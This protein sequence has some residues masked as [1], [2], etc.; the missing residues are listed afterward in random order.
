MNSSLRT[1]AAA[2]LAAG[3]IAASAAHAADHAVAVMYHRFGEDAYPSTNTS[4][5]QIDAHIAHLKSGGFTV[6]PLGEIVRA[7]QSGEPLPDKTVAITIDDAY[8]SVAKVGLPKLKAA[9]FPATIFVATQPIDANLAGYMSWDDVRQALDDG[10]DIGA[11]TVSHA[12]LADLPLDEARREIEHANLRYREELG[13][14]PR[15]FAYPYGEASMAVRAIVQETGYEA[16]FGQHSGVLHASEDMFYL[17]RFAL[18]ERYGAIDRFRTLAAA[19]PMGAR[20]VTPGDMALND[21]NNP[22]AFGFTVDPASGGLAALACYAG[23]VGKLRLEQLGRRIEARMTKR[24][25][26]GR[27]RVNCTLPA[28]PGRWRWFG[29]QFY[30]PKP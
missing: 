13:F 12:H 4:V 23:G 8:R 19:M 18:N 5:G 24:L 2:G 20:D 22:P 11:H 25:G 6:L 30:V 17:P 3:V 28:G 21:R 26:P 14:Q 1:F 16:A 29:R 27:H 9:G 10:F 7:I 15:L